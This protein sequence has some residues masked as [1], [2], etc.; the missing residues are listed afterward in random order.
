MKIL[1]NALFLVLALTSLAQ[2]QQTLRIDYIRRGNFQGDTILL[3]RFVA[4]HSTWAGNPNQPIDPI[5]NGEY[6]VVMADAA[7][8]KP[9]YSRHYNSLFQ[10]YSTTPE[11]RSGKVENLEEVACVPFPTQPVDIIFQKRDAHQTM[12]TQA[13]FRFDPANT[14]VE[15]VARDK[16]ASVLPLK[17]SGNPQNKMDVVIVPEGYGA[18]DK[19]KMMRDMQVFTKCLLDKEPFAGRDTDFN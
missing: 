19:D 2:T 8:G 13:T 1:P 14:T 9:L 15:H 12:Q 10:E 16:A 3:Q 7:T 18:M 4:K 6:C 17:I 5:D 11:G